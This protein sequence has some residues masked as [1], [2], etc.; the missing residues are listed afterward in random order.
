M[1]KN[2]FL[3][4]IILLVG[5]NQKDSFQEVTFNPKLKFTSTEINRV[6]IDSPYTY[7]FSV[8][9]DDPV[10]FSVNLPSWLTYNV[11]NNSISGN[12]VQAGQYPVHI[13]ASTADTTVHQYFMLTV[14]NDETVNILALGNS[15]T[16]GTDH[17]NSYRRVLWQKLHAD[18]YN[19]DF[20][21]SW[22]GHH[23][24]G[25]VPNPDF[26]MNHDGHS[27]WTAENVL[28]PPDWDSVRA[29]ITQ[30][31]THYTPDIV[32]LELGTNEVFQCTS[33]A[34]AIVSLSKII[35]ALR[36]KNPVVKIFLAQIPPLG[37]E[38]VDKK[39]CGDNITY[40]QAVITFNE[41][42]S[43][44]GA[45][46]NT[47]DSP[48]IVVDQFTG[49]NPA[50]DMYDDIHPNEVGEDKMAD[51]WFQAIKDSIKKFD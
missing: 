2:K 32:L 44:F 10:T 50:V 25:L 7:T 13:S 4:L 48:V 12:S 1:M 14:F 41:Q 40:G 21:G 5:C 19:F 49:V 29:N 38:W 18:K 15:I 8:S 31:L 6:S 51:K 45:S 26:D 47:V 28:H 23:M 11:E 36:T 3:I 24:G 27:G 22:N 30:W 16:N 17:Y 46:K 42:L 20:V 37:S 34:N 33:P 9:V 39:L 35:E 43:I